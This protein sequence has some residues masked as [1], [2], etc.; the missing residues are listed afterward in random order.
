MTPVVETKTRALGPYA[1]RDTTLALVVEDIVRQAAHEMAPTVV[2]DEKVDLDLKTVILRLEPDTLEKPFASAQV[3]IEIARAATQQTIYT[4]KVE[5]EVRRLIQTPVPLDDERFPR[6]A[7][8][9]ATSSCL[10]SLFTA[11]TETF[12]GL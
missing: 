8:G 6:T 3:L 9:R 5:S 12:G 1:P 10:R 4:R 7:L 11:V 2:V